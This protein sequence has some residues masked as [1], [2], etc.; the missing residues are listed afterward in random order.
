M[1]FFQDPSLLQFQ[2]RMEDEAHMNNLKTL[3]HVESI[4]KDTQMR[5]ISTRSTRKNSRPSSTTSSVLCREGS[6]LSSTR[7]WTAATLSP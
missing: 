3:F 5:E 6:T 4:P 2:Q 7:S 1:M